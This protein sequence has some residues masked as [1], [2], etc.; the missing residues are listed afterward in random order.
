[1]Q[2][3][4]LS[5][6][7]LF[8]LVIIFTFQLEYA[9][10]DIWRES[11]GATIGGVKSL[12]VNTNNV[13]F[14]Y[15]DPG[16]FARSTNNGN[17]WSPIIIQGIEYFPLTNIV[18]VNNN[19]YVAINN[20][21]V[22]KSTDDG[23]T[24]EQ[25]NVGLTNLQIRCIWIS[26]NGELFLGSGGNI[27]KS[28]NGGETWDY[29]GS[30]P[31]NHWIYA[32]ATGE[33]NNFFASTFIGT[34]QGLLRSIDGGQNWET[35]YTNSEIRTL[36][37]S[38]NG[39]IYAGG[40]SGLIRSTNNGNSWQ[41]IESSI[42]TD[43]AIYID[44]NDY[45]FFS[46][47]GGNGI[48]K[49]T[50]YGE[51]WISFGLTGKAIMS[52]AKNNN[53]DFFAGHFYT[54]IYR[55]TN[56]GLIWTVIY[57]SGI[58][59]SVEKLYTNSNGFVYAKGSNRRVYFSNDNG[60]QWN[61]NDTLPVGDLGINSNNI[62]FCVGIN[63]DIYRSTDYGYTWTFLKYFGSLEAPL[64]ILCLKPA[65]NIFIQQYLYSH[66]LEQARFFVQRIMEKLGI[67]LVLM[68]YPLKQLNTV[69][70]K[71]FLHQVPVISFVQQME[72]LIGIL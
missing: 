9:Q 32:L 70:K 68:V 5:L 44:S 47:G 40:S 53:G 69:L 37:I 21:G 33:N 55:T 19:V 10:S 38:S 63:N 31:A 18:A 11:N 4:V 25:K 46:K 59:F 17:S 56:N 61:K 7:K 27:F 41:V 45:I 42:Q 30:V 49:S 60:E 26:N 57:N 51:N 13:I 58:D 20:L 36:N 15:G 12:A 34:F 67:M 22:Y 6:R 24:W 35:V 8:F 43:R 71:F 66:I 29:V 3:I 54:G 64:K 2:K 62:L 16:K 39:Y 65:S 52:I 50:D 72:A 48:I 23:E 14:A 1:M 28:N